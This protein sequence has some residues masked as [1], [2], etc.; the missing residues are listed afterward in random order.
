LCASDFAHLSI[1]R[2]MGSFISKLISGDH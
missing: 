2:T 1:H